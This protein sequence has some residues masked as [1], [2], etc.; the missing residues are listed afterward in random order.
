MTRRKTNAIRPLI[1]LSVLAVL[2]AP[3]GQSRAA[4]ESGAEGGPQLEEIIVTAQ[5]RTQNLRDVP[6]AIE[7]FKA[8]A[9]ERQHINTNQDLSFAVPTL[10]FTENLSISVPF[11]RG[12]GTDLSQPNIDPSVATYNDGVFVPSGQSHIGNLLGVDRVE[13]LSGPQGTLYGRNAVAGT[14]NIISLTPSKELE[15]KASVR[16]GRY[17]S[18]EVVL[19]VSGPLSDTLSAGLYVAGTE[20]DP[21]LDKYR[22]IGPFRA[23]NPLNTG[24]YTSPSQEKQGGARAKVVWTPVEAVKLTAMVQKLTETSYDGTALR[25]IDPNALGFVLGAAPPI[26]KDYTVLESS[27]PGQRVV[28]QST[29]ASLREEVDLGSVKLLGISAYSRGEFDDYINVDG[30]GGDLVRTRPIIP[31]RAMSQ[32]IQLLSADKSA[33]QWIAGLYFFRENT[34]YSPTDIIV[35]NGIE[36]ITD[37]IIT[38]SYAA[39]AQATI[40]I[41]ETW[42]LTLGGRY[43]IEDKFATSQSD[44]FIDT[45]GAQVFKFIY[46]D[47]SR[48]WSKF[49]PKVTVDYRIGESLLYATYSEGFK[50][51]AYNV[52]APSSPAPA[53]PET[54]KAYEVGAKSSF[55]NNRI[56]LNA[57]AYYYEV[58]DL[59][60][61]VLLAQRGSAGILQ[62][63]GG[64]QV[65]GVEATV[66]AAA[67]S[68]LTLN[69]SVGYQPISKYTNFPNYSGVD[70]SL[71]TQSVDVS[72]NRL[73]RAPKWVGSAGISYEHELSGAS[74]IHANINWAYTGS[75]YWTPQNNAIQKGYSRVNAA[76][77]YEFLDRR[78]DL[79][80]WGSNLLDTH[81]FTNV[82]PIAGVGHFAQDAE[83]RMYGVRATYRF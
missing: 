23:A 79:S 66:T 19:Y 21:Y 31:S 25:Q 28:I 5:K 33:V 18:K 15:G 22:F 65:K 55:L 67:T 52:A 60:T 30:T 11:L 78:L 41:W 6:I 62:N 83:P 69:G 77:G 71:A 13:V 68:E 54:L 37:E 34:G 47:G 8:A 61:F 59:Q 27:S 17:N 29:S 36:S 10:V 24:P 81:Y 58:K 44:G 40:P 3:S 1:A 50:S 20:Q 48:R 38:K 74:Q 73:Q 82:Y 57:A 32:E 53:N 51:G 14:I 56:Q 46:P 75:F 72:G 7:A 49:T 45:T 4:D 63:A 70:S 26:I 42:R 39:F 76:L 16:Y 2:L 80:V 12:I 43:T 9:L 64:A 35:P